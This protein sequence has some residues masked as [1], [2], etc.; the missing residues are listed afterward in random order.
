[1]EYDNNNSNDNF[2]YQQLKILDKALDILIEVDKAWEISRS[3][4]NLAFEIDQQYSVHEKVSNI[5]FT[6][7]AAAIKAGVAYK[8]S[9]S[10]KELK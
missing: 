1:M 8:N 10:Y 5:L 6:S 9:P 2:E 7:M 4:I 3:G